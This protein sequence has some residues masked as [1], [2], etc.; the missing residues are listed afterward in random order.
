M[1]TMTEQDLFDPQT[2]SGINRAIN[3]ADEKIMSWSDKALA[4]LTLYANR[5][6]Q[7]FCATHVRKWAT[8]QGLPEPP[9]KLA[10]GG[11]FQ[12][13]SRAGIIQRTRSDYFNEFESDNTHA[14]IVTFW[15]RA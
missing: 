10:W 7:E 2:Q 12:R 15:K 11:V 5:Y 1:H 14:Q 9:S 3:H 4:F 8:K 6:D 13:A